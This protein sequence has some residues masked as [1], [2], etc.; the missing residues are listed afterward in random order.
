MA[1]IMHG[2]RLYWIQRVS[3][4]ATVQHGERHPHLLGADWGA[5]I[6]TALVSGEQEIRRH[7]GG[8]RHQAV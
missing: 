3:I 1:Q 4:P 8:R 5:G 7:S 2:I 6:N